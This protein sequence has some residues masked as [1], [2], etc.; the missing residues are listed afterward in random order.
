MPV[1]FA[2]ALQCEDLQYSAFQF[3]DQSIKVDRYSGND[4]HINHNPGSHWHLLP[5]EAS[6]QTPEHHFQRQILAP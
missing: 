1:T 4:F 5:T 3:G 2:L 6:L